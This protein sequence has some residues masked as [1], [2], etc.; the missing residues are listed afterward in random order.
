MLGISL[1]P[2]HLDL[3]LKT[4]DIGRFLGVQGRQ[5]E[6]PTPSRSTLGGQDG[7]AS[8][9]PRLCTGSSITCPLFRDSPFRSMLSSNLRRT[10]ECWRA[11][12]APF[13][14]VIYPI[15]RFDWAAVATAPSA[16]ARIWAV[17]ALT[18]RMF[19]RALATVRLDTATN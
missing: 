11:H 8:S 7:G 15:A 17:D 14:L 19:S 9:F 3:H 5:S 18:R 12:G 2:L 13:S 1:R 10:G 6:G 4:Q 16:S